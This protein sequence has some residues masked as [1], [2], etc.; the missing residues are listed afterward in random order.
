MGFLQKTGVDRRCG[1]DKWG[2]EKPSNRSL[3]RR[4]NG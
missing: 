4:N 2:A 3:V 1:A